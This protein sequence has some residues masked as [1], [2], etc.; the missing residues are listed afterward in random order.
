MVS[1]EVMRAAN[2]LS[3]YDAIQVD[4]RI[5]PSAVLRERLRETEQQLLALTGA[6]SVEL[7]RERVA[8]LKAAATSVPQQRK[9]EPAAKKTKKPKPT[10]HQPATGYYRGTEDG[11]YG[12]RQPGRTMPARITSVVGG[13]LPETQRRH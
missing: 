13:G 2:A 3:R 12:R 9:A 5:R 10:K 6:A 7:A 11:N 4:L 8:E 1:S